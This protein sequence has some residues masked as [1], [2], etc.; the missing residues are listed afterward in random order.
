[1]IERLKISIRSADDKGE[2][3]RPAATQTVPGQSGQESDA[4]ARKRLWLRDLE[5]IRRPEP[6][7]PVGSKVLEVTI[8]KTR[9]SKA[10]T[11]K[12]DGQELEVINLTEDSP[13]KSSQS[14]TDMD[15][16]SFYGLSD[17]KLLIFQDQNTDQ[18]KTPA[19]TEGLEHHRLLMKKFRDTYNLPSDLSKEEEAEV[20]GDVS[21]VY[22]Y[23]EGW[24]NDHDQAHKA[25]YKAELTTGKRKHRTPLIKGL[26]LVE[27]VPFLCIPNYQGASGECFWKAIA[28]HIYGDWRYHHRVKG[29]HFAHFCHI[30][31]E[32][33]HPRHESY[34][35]LNKKFYA[36]KTSPEG[37]K[38]TNTCANL[39]QILCMPSTYTPLNMFDVTADLYHVFLIIYTLNEK[40]EITFVTTRGSY[41]S[42][43]LF[44][45]YVGNNH[46]QPLVPN[47]FW[48]SE[49][50][51]PMITLE[52]TNVYPGL[53]GVPLTN[54]LKAKDGI[55]H[56]WR[57]ETDRQVAQPID[58]SMESGR[59]PAAQR[60]HRWERKERKRKENTVMM[61][62]K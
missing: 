53:L 34:K 19:P 60:Q 62:T 54:A 37:G 25:L 57:R 52:S 40:Q 18:G 13:T 46:Y 6:L 56:R 4:A 45:L 3:Q 51:L 15:P 23:E 26:P 17:E 11:K 7:V 42:R 43:H 41:N 10:N 16:P 36:T 30:L 61:C 2:Q 29:E 32:S 20:Y 47:E 55:E 12:D 14:T 49:F 50:R 27:E 22:S 39:Y 48:A 35:A 21:S 44:I 8:P 38:P 31:R 59:G 5:T 58:S 28:I 1:M 9:T 24:P 33:K